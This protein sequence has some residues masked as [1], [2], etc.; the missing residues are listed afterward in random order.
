M[1][2][3][4]L[5][6]SWRFF[7]RF[8]RRTWSVISDLASAAWSWIKDAANA[9]KEEF[10]ALGNEMSGAKDAFTSIFER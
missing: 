8:S 3:L 9:I 5:L 10:E 2:L 7:R 1:Q 4:M 6:L